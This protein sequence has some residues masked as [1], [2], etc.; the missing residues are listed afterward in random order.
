MPDGIEEHVRILRDTRVPHIAPS[1]QNRYEQPKQEIPRTVS[2]PQLSKP[3]TP[4]A[5]TRGPSDPNASITATREQADRSNPGVL[6]RRSNR[7]DAHDSIPL[8]TL[9]VEDHPGPEIRS[10]QSP[11]KNIKTSSQNVKEQ[12]SRGSFSKPNTVPKSHPST[13]PPALYESPG[14]NLG[15]QTHLQAGG[16]T[17]RTSPFPSQV[18]SSHPIQEQGSYAPLPPPQQLPG[19]VTVTEPILEERVLPA[20]VTAKTHSRGLSAETGE[21]SI[22]TPVLAI[23]SKMGEIPNLTG[24]VDVSR[25]PTPIGGELAVF[26]IGELR[27]AEVMFKFDWNQVLNHL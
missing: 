21:D 27:G 8:K 24:L 23:I 22:P 25:H 4:P 2:K 3:P 13:Q 20:K 10:D 17:Q 11:L 16:S 12:L 14:T 1:T 6:S 15:T 19:S 18:P 26:Y 5:Q 9:K 7:D